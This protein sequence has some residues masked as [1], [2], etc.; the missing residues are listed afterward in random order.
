M[1]E[2]CPVDWESWE[3]EMRAT[4]MFVRVGDEVLLIEKQRGIG[5]G[6]INGPGGK[7]DPGE[8]PLECAIRETQEELHITA[9]GVRKMGELFFAMSDIPQ[10]HC[11]VFLATGYEGEPTA[12]EEAIPCWTPVDEIPFERMW[13]DDRHW[14]RE[15][16]DGQAFEGRFVFE[17]ELIVWKDVKW[18]GESGSWEEENPLGSEC[19]AGS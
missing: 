10:I 17:G 8:T 2:V 4:L 11:H 16:L 5:A 12:T 19:G 14:L 13:E 9:K 15:M 18:L 7:I 1:S 3:P 6:K